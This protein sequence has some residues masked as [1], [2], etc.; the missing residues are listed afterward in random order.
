MERR[1]GRPA[2]A[3][4][5][6]ARG[7]GKR[8]GDVIGT[9]MGACED[10][11]A[12]QVGASA[13]VWGGSRETLG[14]KT[15]NQITWLWLLLNGKGVGRGKMCYV[16]G[17]DWSCRKA[18]RMAHRRGRVNGKQETGNRGRGARGE[19]RGSVHGTCSV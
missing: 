15:V 1:V 18:R 14:K 5:E 13:A 19:G 12:G 7:A 6:V 2:D 10:G 8:I 11:G 4:N 9:I 16:K 17:L 3:I